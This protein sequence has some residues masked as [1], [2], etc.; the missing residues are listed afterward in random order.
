VGIRAERWIT[1]QKRRA[2]VVAIIDTIAYVPGTQGFVAWGGPLAHPRSV[3][4]EGHAHTVSGAADVRL[5]GPH[6]AGGGGV[7]RGV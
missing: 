4:R 6:R 1:W 2:S 7:R 3:L 5:C